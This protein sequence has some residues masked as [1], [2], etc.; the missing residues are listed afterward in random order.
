MT[1]LRPLPYLLLALLLGAA[2]FAGG[3]L[4]DPL[5]RRAPP[6]TRVSGSLDPEAERLTRQIARLRAERS[7][8]AAELQRTGDELAAAREELAAAKAEIERLRTR[9]DTAETAQDEAQQRVDALRGRVADLDARQSAPAP[10]DTPEQDTPEQDTDDGDTA[11]PDASADA[12]ARADS[13]RDSA[14]DS[15]AAPAGPDNAGSQ[16]PRRARPTQA[17][18]DATA[19]SPVQRERVR[20]GIEAYRAQ[21]Y[22]EAYEMWLEPAQAGVAR[23]QFHL[24][25]LFFEGRGV[26]QDNR[27]AYAWLTLAQENGSPAAG[28]LLRRLEDRIADAERE[29]AIDLITNSGQ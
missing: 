9:L 24:G 16:A 5:D 11:R 15:G 19:P 20:A 10:P 3:V 4:L 1:V 21:A 12:G 27:L 13:G 29:A 8:L 18:L 23:A 26:P 22:V 7:E 17:A 2:G 28:A 6:Q 14:A 25:A